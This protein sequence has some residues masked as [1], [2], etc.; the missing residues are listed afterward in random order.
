M[1]KHD[2]DQA[3]CWLCAGFKPGA[4]NDEAH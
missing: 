3:F 4:D 1:I 2:S